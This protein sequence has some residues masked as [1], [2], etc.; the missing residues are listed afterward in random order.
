MEHWKKLYYMNEQ[1]K[2]I[3]T[4]YTVSDFGNVQNIE[5][6]KMIKATDASN[7]HDKYMMVRLNVGDKKKSFRL[8]KLVAE[9]FVENPHDYGCVTH[10]DGDYK[11]NA[12]SNLK[13]VPLS[14][15]AGKVKRK[16]STKDV[17]DIRMSVVKGDKENGINKTCEKYNVTKE[18]IRN[19]V[20]FKSYVSVKDI[21][22][23]GK[24]VMDKADNC[25]NSA[26][27]LSL[28]QESITALESLKTRMPL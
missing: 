13:W 5:T 2:L 21:H 19:I 8:H 4:R 16:F 23:Y 27:A 17:V 18:T 7:D 28:L 6:G 9:L 24:A 22:A 10:K 3:D 26:T 1:G 14:T 25:V 11:N 12:A 15:T 20:D